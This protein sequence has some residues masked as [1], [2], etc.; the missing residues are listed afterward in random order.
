MVYSLLLWRHP[1]IRYRQAL[2][3]ICRCELLSML[4]SLSLEAEIVTDSFGN[5]LFLTFECR[6]LTERELSYLGSHSCGE[7]IA[8]KH[9]ELLRPVLLNSTDLFPEDL[10]ELLKYKGKTN[11]VFTRMM[12]NTAFALSSF[13]GSSSPLTILDPLCGHGTTLFCAAC[14]G[15]DSVGIDSDQKAIKEGTD[16]FSRYLRE[17]G[18]K[19]EIRAFHSTVG[20]GIPGKEFLFAVNRDAWKQHDV[21]TM[22]FHV[23]DTVFTDKLLKKNSIHMLVADLPYGVQHAPRQ[24]SAEDRFSE[25]LP[26]LLPAW[27]S[28]LKPGGMIALSFNVFTLKRSA[29]LS[30]L[31]EAGFL[32]VEEP[33]FQNLEHPVEQAVRRDVVFAGVH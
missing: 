10:P 20:S 6:E 23:G 13:S 28:V 11:S 5:S 17:S 31:V 14:M 19:H 21:R 27:K 29:V 33:A 15:H 2:L 32:P 1:N 26:R 9:G 16:F 25:F 8:E 12:L 3:P 7:F 18:K 4:R 24:E 30:A 22:T